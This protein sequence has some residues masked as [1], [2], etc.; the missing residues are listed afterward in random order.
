MFHTN[1]EELSN[2]AHLLLSRL[3]VVYFFVK[4]DMQRVNYWF[5]DHP[6]MIHTTL[7]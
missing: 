3:F 5:N 1:P 4:A 6:R 7:W 2:K